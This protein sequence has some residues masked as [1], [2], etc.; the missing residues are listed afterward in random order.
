MLLPFGRVFVAVWVVSSKGPWREWLILAIKSVLF[1]SFFFKESL[2]LSM[3]EWL[4]REKN[5]YPKRTR[6]L[7]R[8]EIEAVSHDTLLEDSPDE[9]LINSIVSMTGFYQETRQLPPLKE[10]CIFIGCVLRFKNLRPAAFTRSKG[11]LFWV[12]GPEQAAHSLQTVLDGQFGHA[13]EF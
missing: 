1:L 7:E 9:L 11:K 5:E 8:T 10:V 3:S 13:S 4:S 12:R 6:N 2:F